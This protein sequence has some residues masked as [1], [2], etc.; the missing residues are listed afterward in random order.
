MVLAANGQLFCWSWIG[1]S[2][3]KPES[4]GTTVAI[5]M[6]DDECISIRADGAVLRWV[7]DPWQIDPPV[8]IANRTLLVPAAAQGA[9]HIVSGADHHLA[10]MPGGTVFAFGG[11]NLHGQTTVPAGLSGVIAIA[12]GDGFS[13]ALKNDGNIVGWGSNTSGALTMPSGLTDVV[14]LSAGRGSAIAQHA[15]GHITTWGTEAVVGG[16]TPTPAGIDHVIEAGTAAG[17]G[18]A[19]RSITQPISITQQ[20]QSMRVFFDY[21]GPGFDVSANSTNALSYQWLSNGYV[22]PGATSATMPIQYAGYWNGTSSGWYS[23]VITTSDASITTTPAQPCVAAAWAMLP[24]T[25]ARRSEAP[26][27]TTSTWP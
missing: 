22:I 21:T 7:T 13:L 1:G 5:S 23:C 26:P 11:A 19:L 20:P 16:I 15:E 14:K 18:I 3:F 6:S 12:A 17:I 10:L 24:P 4:T 9:T 27:S 8:P 25:K 2:S